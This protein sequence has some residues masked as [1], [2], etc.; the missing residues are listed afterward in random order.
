MFFHHDTVL[1]LSEKCHLVPSLSPGLFPHP[2]IQIPVH[3]HVLSCPGSLAPLLPPLFHFPEWKQKYLNYLAI[4]KK[5][6]CLFLNCTDYVLLEYSQILIALIAVLSWTQVSDREN[7]SSKP[8]AL[9][10]SV[11]PKCG[12]H[13]TVTSSH[14][15][16]PWK[17]KSTNWSNAKEFL[18]VPLLG[19]L[20]SNRYG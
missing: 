13:H 2:S 10:V 18:V 11:I 5:T 1:R 7:I 6:I 3:T 15:I 14:S 12:S 17:T 16:L 19:E 4:I 9:R 20:Q 8:V